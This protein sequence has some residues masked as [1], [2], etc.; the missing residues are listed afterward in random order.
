MK[1]ISLGRI[2]VLSLLLVVAFQVLY[3]LGMLF[4]GSF[5]DAPPGLV[6]NFS[7][8]GYIAVYSDPETYSLILRTFW[9]AAVRVAVTLGLAIFL[10]WGVTRTDIPGRRPL[11]WSIMLTFFMPYLPKVMAWIL[12][13]SPRS[14]YINQF[15]RLF[16]PI[17][18]QGLN[19]FS[20][21]GI[22]FT[23]AML[24]APMLFILLVPAFRAM[25]ASLEESSLMSGASTWSTIRRIDLPLLTP[26]LLAAGTLGFVRMMESFMT[27]ALL[28]I[29]A[30]IYVV[31]TKI[32]DYVAYSVPPAYPPAMALAIL[33]LVIT[34]SIVALQWKVLGR[35]QYTTVSGKGYQARPV[36]LGMLRYPVFFGIVIVIALNLFLPL[37]TL[38]WSSFMKHAG[39]F[40][41]NMYTFKHWQTALSDPALLKAIGNTMG[42]SATSATIGM[43]LCSLIGYV[44]IKTRFRERAALDMTAWI[45]WAVPAIVMGLA[46]LW[47]YTLLPLPFGI[48]L[49]GSMAL[50]IL[51][52][53]TKGFPLGT[54]TMTT[55]M[56]QLSNEL[57]ESSRVHGA[58]WA[59]TFTRI[60]LPLVSP[61]FLAGW[62][63]LFSLA[64]KDLPT[65]IFMANTKTNVISTAI[66]QWWSLG[67]IEA[68]MIIGLIQA[69]ILA[70]AYFISVAV[71]RQVI[72]RTL[73]SL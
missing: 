47:A 39:L 57:E 28:G 16:L 58:S 53:I 45:P 36:P 12:L 46:F 34:L 2:L 56:I 37:A 64:A 69:A 19:I 48:T 18:E 51:V 15:L 43:I 22:I 6:G 54:R 62:I 30:N 7:F 68:A 38:V 33:L 65:V 41:D 52:F 20:Y 13:L 49:Y 42:M 29:P 27:E 1:R 40:M 25:D 10:A 71:R 31:T 8:K 23:S 59:R 72:V 9:L 14:G 17:G 66:F 24:D 73:D 4:Y 26:A 70:G 21:G 32:Y 67:F 50:L 11:E 5:K 44:V 35:R 3:P 63:L 60:V 55:T 61:G